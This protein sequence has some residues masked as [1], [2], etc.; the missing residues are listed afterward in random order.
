MADSALAL[1]K[2]EDCAKWCYDKDGGKTIRR[3]EPVARR[4]PPPCHKCPKT[5]GR[6]SRTFEEGQGAELSLKNWKTLQLYYEEGHDLPPEDAILRRNFG[7]IRQLMDSHGRH[8]Q[9][10]ITM[11]LTNLLTL[12]AR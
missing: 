11:Q 7:T 5:A 4:G 3:G 2:C 12:V 9:Q 6:D 1:R 10:M 8:Q